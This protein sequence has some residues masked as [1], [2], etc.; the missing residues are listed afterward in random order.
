M[1]KLSPPVQLPDPSAVA[2]E[3]FDEIWDEAT[4]S[5]ADTG[6]QFAAVKTQWGERILQ[7]ILGRGEP[8]SVGASPFARRSSAVAPKEV[9]D[10]MFDRYRSGGYTDKAIVSHAKRVSV[11]YCPYCGLYLRRKPHSTNPD[12]DH[13][14]PRSLFPEFSLMRLNLVVV[15][16]DCNNAKLNKDVDDNGDWLFIHP[17]FDDFLASSILISDISVN[18]GSPVIDFKLRS[19]LD[20]AVFHRVERH[21]KTLDLFA[22]Y[23]DDPL[24]DAV[25]ILEAHQGHIVA[26]SA[27]VALVR[28]LLAEQGQRLLESRP[29]D[30][31][32]A[33]LI[34]LSKTQDLELL[35]RAPRTLPPPVLAAQS[36]GGTP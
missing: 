7:Y 11:E 34:G 24:R 3:C 9:G 25:Q 13:I 26:G 14:R 5:Q 20:S 8:K 1:I 18:N 16:D 4:H 33:I 15:C 10:L 2:Q 36:A 29:N 6:L 17:Y 22:R 12:R 19:N 31:V 21:V 30:P 23:R 35:L 27:D 32:G 28:R